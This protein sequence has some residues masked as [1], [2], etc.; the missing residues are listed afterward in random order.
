MDLS[1][2]RSVRAASL[3]IH[4]SGSEQYWDISLPGLDP[5]HLKS[6]MH[7]LRKERQK[8]GE[9]LSHPSLKLKHLLDNLSVALG[10][11]SFEHWIHDVQPSLQR[12]FD[13][14][15]LTTPAD[16]ITWK[17][18]PF[19]HPL[20]PRQVADRL[21]ASGLP[22]PEK[23]FTGVDNEMFAARSYGAMDLQSAV[24]RLTGKEFICSWPVREQIRFVL[25]QPEEP[26]MPAD[27]SDIEEL[28]DPT[29]SKMT[30]RDLLLLTFRWDL[31]CSF[32][33]LGDNLVMPQRRE[34]V[35]RF[36]NATEEE[37]D[38]MATI[39]RL[40]RD[41][42]E[43]TAV[44]WV[45]VLPFNENL[46]FLRGSGG[47]F[48]WVVRDQRDE[49]FSG[50]KLHPIFA[51]DEIPT[52]LSAGIDI[53]AKL[54]FTKGLWLD[55]IEHNS[56]LHYYGTGGTLATYPGAEKIVANYLQATGAIVPKKAKGG[57]RQLDFV[58][59][60]LADK[61]L[62]VSELIT[63]DE[64][65]NFYENEWAELRDA[66]ADR[67]AREWPPL[68]EMNGRD[69]GDKPVCVNWFDAVAYCKYLERRTGLPVRLLS[70]EEWQAIAPSRET[71]K[72]IGPKARQ[73]VVEAVDPKGNVLEPPTYLPHYYTRFKPDLCWVPNTE[74]LNFL[75]SL[76][77]GEWL[78]D[79]RGSAP[80]HV[81][82]PVACTASGIALG[83]GP[84]ER[85]FFE[86]W[87]VGRNNHLKVG[88]RVCYVA[89]P[90][91]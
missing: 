17:H 29:Y 34:P 50:N 72:A 67:A 23:I 63:I 27:L 42:M 2:L 40:F 66:K 79:Y 69:E 83:R 46:V 13:S 28:V 85:E 73:A 37:L 71:V 41:E 49:Q 22:M 38:A 10:G 5:E 35:Y 70:I 31:G 4:K 80:N 15:G 52:A 81:F 55:Q 91:S 68:L 78:G 21:F 43:R 53:K 75:S 36:Y 25:S 47:R 86:A 58:A 87:Y 26:V 3:L 82:A 61:C 30:L 18:P 16:L 7:T 6:A 12:F 62:M 90:D 59:H 33:L 76:T 11:K 32:N 77:F 89:N 51:A 44:G 19:A 56:E 45:D 57:T 48:D 20:K 14:H 84:L 1:L 74:G 9:A 88:F 64:F 24:A 60:A 8:A 54:H 65:W 39:Y